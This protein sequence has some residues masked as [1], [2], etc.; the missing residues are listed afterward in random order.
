MGDKAT[1]VVSVPLKLEYSYQD[2]K[3]GKVVEIAGDNGVAFD[4]DGKVQIT[5]PSG[6]LEKIGARF[7][8]K[9]V[10]DYGD[11]T[12][13][14]DENGAIVFVDSSAPVVSVKNIVLTR[15]GNNE[16]AIDYDTYLS[17]ANKWAQSVSVN[18]TAQ[19]D[20][21]YI[22]SIS[23]SYGDNTVD[24]TENID[25]SATESNL[26]YSTKAGIS[27]GGE[28]ATA[29]L[30]DGKNTVTLSA[31]N[32]VGISGDKDVDLYIDNTNPTLDFSYDYEDEG[33]TS[34]K[35]GVAYKGNAVTVKIKAA[36]K[37]S[38]VSDLSVSVERATSIAD[39]STDKDPYSAYAVDVTKTSSD[40]AKVKLEESGYY[41]ITAT[42][43]DKAGNAYTVKKLAYVDAT[44]LKPELT[45]EAIKNDTTK[46]LKTDSITNGDKIKI[47]YTVS[48]FAMD[49]N[50]VNVTITRTPFTTSSTDKEESID[51]TKVCSEPD[52]SGITTVSYTYIVEGE[53]SQGTYS[54]KVSANNHFAKNTVVK[55]NFSFI[56]D[57]DAPDILSVGCVNN[58]KGTITNKDS[59]GVYRYK[60]TVTPMLHLKLSDNYS[61]AH[62]TIVDSEDN[63]L[64][65]GNVKGTDSDSYVKLSN[66]KKNTIYTV[67]IKASDKAGNEVVKE[68]KTVSFAIDGKAPTLSIT[69]ASEISGK[70]FNE[71]VAVTY[72]VEDDN[73]VD[74]IEVSGI[75]GNTNVATITV[76][77]SQATKT[78]TYKTQGKYNLTVK[79]YDK[80]GN[81]S[82]VRK[83]NFV[84]DKEKPSGSYTLDVKRRAAQNNSITFDVKD[85]FGIKDTDIVLTYKYKLADSDEW[86]TKELKAKNGSITV[87]L[88]EKDGTP[89]VYK[90]F[91]VTA[92][93]KAGNTAKISGPKTALYIDETQPSV[94]ISPY[95]TDNDGYYNSA[96]AF[97]IIF[98]EQ[99]ALN[100]SLKVNKIVTDNG[101][102]VE[103]KTDTIE[104]ITDVDYTQAKTYT[105]Q[106]KYTIT[107]TAT[108]E[109]GNVYNSKDVGDELTFIIDT[110]KPVVELGA[111]NKLN[112]SDVTLPFT[113]TDN[114]KGLS[115]EVDVERKNASGT[116]VSSGVYTSGKWNNTE[117]TKSLTFSEEG[118][119]T[120][121]ISAKDKA[122][123]TSAAKTATFRIDKTAPALTISGVNDTQASSCTATI[124]VDEAFPFSFDGQ[125]LAAGDIN[126]TITKKTDGTA[127]SNI[128]TLSTSSFSAGN[129][130]TATYSFTEDGEYTITATAKDLAGNTAATATKT[131]K[132]DSNAPELTIAAV[133]KNSK[134]VNSY[135]SIGS[136]SETDPNYVDMSIQVQEAFFATNDVNISV[137][138]DGK[139]V[140]SEYFKNYSNS[141]EISKGSQRFSEDGVYNV[142]VTA[143]DQLGNAAEDYNIVF[144][145]DNTP[146]T[147]EPS[148][149]LAAFNQKATDGEDGTVLLNAEDFADI[150]GSGY[151]AL[152]DVNDTSV[153]TV[154]AKMDGVNLVDFSDLSDG[155]HKISLTVTDEV[156]HQSQQ[157]FEFT[158]DGTAPRI[159]ITGVEDKDV[160][161]DPFTMT[162]G[163][164]NDE[165]EITSIVINGETIDPALYQ[166]TNS[167]EM[168]VEEYDKYTVEVT[169]TDKAGNISST[170]DES[171][172]EYFSFRLSEKVNPIVLIIIIIIILLLAALLVFVIISS[173]KKK[174]TE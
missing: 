87:E 169:A 63:I 48:G 128:A 151:E 21:S 159:I 133:D 57:I 171:T 83:L 116:V 40:E 106:G 108:D 135:D 157:E 126:V 23:Y 132:V 47:S 38:G 22:K 12:Y 18:V 26:T 46:E 13:W 162:I 91:V 174:K 143:K 15:G 164:E 25:Y 89:V 156:G 139:E 145:V 29:K 101:V 9:I 141:A 77:K 123:N 43:T 35:G 66:L 109:A 130:H 172:G 50:D 98:K 158:Y 76:N 75:A 55:N 107:I 3:T 150:L 149:K 93:D 67:K 80:A 95:P 32:Y 72:K 115:Y 27:F 90:N 138:K 125:N 5:I 28:N 88:T 61:L 79:A 137:S 14:Q 84:I 148:A 94:D 86:K 78:V 69:N 34:G 37:T 85:N 62:Y 73:E 31:T 104:P 102:E 113:L 146:P 118:D 134:T 33:D 129:P 60:S 147:V 127:A 153:F 165:D 155:Y 120:V 152:W 56:Y 100:S 1:G 7:I 140:S 105:R 45:V 54:I 119:Y 167:Y 103:N 110:T 6:N 30:S 10:D 166:Q 2:I 64:A 163:L 51:V 39:E 74:R 117:T 59:N 82:S 97:D 70:Y 136:Q 121:T 160:K 170:Y 96:V 142:S 92:T 124:A 36:D 65:E 161:N 144:T 131:F 8:F 114:Y 99:F 111:V 4:D 81:V 173:R 49:E 122:G 19:E 168:Q 53:K 17:T 24:I 16:T 44:V 42:A 68:I 58:E 20:T 52:A 41:R 11:S 112:N 154:D 71:N